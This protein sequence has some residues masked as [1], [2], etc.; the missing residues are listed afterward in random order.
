LLLPDKESASASSNQ[1]AAVAEQLGISYVTENIAAAV[2]A[3]GCYRHRDEAIRVVFPDFAAGWKSKIVIAPT[4]NSGLS[5]FKLVVQKPDGTQLEERLP[6]R[7]YLQI[8][9]STN[10]KQRVRKAIEYFHAD[11]LGYAVIGTPN[12]LEYDQ[13][14][15]VKGG[16]GLADIKPIAHLY[17]TQVYALARYLGLPEAVCNARPT[18]DTYSLA[19]G[20]DEF[21]FGLPYEKMD[22]A[23]WCHNHAVSV[24]EFAAAVGLPL[25]AA[26]RVYQDI[27]SKRTSTAYLHSAALLVDPVTQLPKLMSPTV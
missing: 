26:T 20:Q 1:G 8:V 12:R 2:E 6:A 25:D 19:Q 18:T 7:Q 14:F 24:T 9:A 5:Y 3:L 16:D 23:L 13:G 10:Y 4:V 21:Y 27:E 22:I 17:K 15:F 11:R